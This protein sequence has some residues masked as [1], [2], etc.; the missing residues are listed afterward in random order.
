[1]QKTARKNIKYSRNVKARY[2]AWAIAFAKY[3]IWP[4]KFNCLKH[5][6]IDSASL[7]EIFC[8][9]SHSKKHQI[10]EKWDDFENRPS[11]KGYSLCIGYSVCKI[12]NLG[13]K[14]KLPKTCQSRFCKLIKNILCKKTARKNTKYSR[15]ET[16]LKI[17]H[18]AFEWAIDICKILNLGQ[19]CKLPKTCQNR[20]CKLIKNILCKKPLEKT[21]NIPEMRR[22]WKSAILQRL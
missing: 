3:S 10:F 16:I 15:N 22:F 14:C 4:K 20:F 5:V 19:K 6:K 17:G 8:A 13:Q 11:C 21:P 7:L 9:K 12:L 2:F 18:L 1:M